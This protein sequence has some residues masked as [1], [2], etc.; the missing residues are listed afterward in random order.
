M[1]SSNF[2]KSALEKKNLKKKKKKWKLTCL[3]NENHDGERDSDSQQYQ[4]DHNGEDP[5]PLQ[6]TPRP[7]DMR[8][9]FPTGNPS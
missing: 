7:Q 4:E 9:S 8:Q 2:L 6:D 1:V 3:P 5:A